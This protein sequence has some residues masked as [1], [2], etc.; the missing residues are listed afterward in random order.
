MIEYRTHENSPIT[1]IHVEEGAV[2]VTMTF[3]SL[4]EFTPMHA[5]TF[6]HWMECMEGAAL[7]SI[8]GIDTVV[9]K[10]DKYMVEA[11]KEHSAT[12]LESHTVLRCVHE[13]DEVD[14]DKCG[15]GIPHEWIHRLTVH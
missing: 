4:F 8:D 10:G 14:P 9:R 3:N 5:H 1:S 12:P 13:N 2:I 11:G 6:D 7:I 15:E